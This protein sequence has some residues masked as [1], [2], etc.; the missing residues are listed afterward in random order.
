MDSPKRRETSIRESDERD[1][2]ALGALFER[3]ESQLAREGEVTTKA[4]ALSTPTR[5]TLTACAIAALT[6]ALAWLSPRPDLDGTP[7][8]STL[9]TVGVY[10]TLSVALTTVALRPLQRLDLPRRLERTLGGVAIV[11][12]WLLA[13]WT[14]HGPAP[15]DLP[16]DCLALGLG[17]GVLIV[18][19]LCVLDR[20]SGKVRGSPLVVAA[21]GGLSANLALT[22][23]CHAQGLHLALIHAP[24][25][26]VLWVLLTIYVRCSDRP[27]ERLRA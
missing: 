27:T 23:H 12:P 10:L 25:S 4:R 8:L 17:F 9:M 3:L 15:S 22:V 13:A 19:V 16:R 1:R 14:T 21:V 6:A 26:L 5:L 24:L 2:A 7:R 20:A 18:L 11:A